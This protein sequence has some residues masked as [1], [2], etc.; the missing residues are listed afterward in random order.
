VGSTSIT[1]AGDDMDVVNDEEEED[2]AEDEQ[3]TPKSPQRAP[4]KLHGRGGFM[5]PR[6]A[7]GGR[8]RG[9]GRGRG[10]GNA[11]APLAAIQASETSNDPMDSLASDMSALQFVPHSVRVARGARRGGA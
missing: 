7:R 11:I 5:H 1:N 4:I 8:G 6:G 9:R 3:P 10:I 2:D